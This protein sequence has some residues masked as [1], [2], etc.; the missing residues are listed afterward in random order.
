M[1]WLVLSLE[2]GP[3]NCVLDWAATVIKTHPDHKIIINTHAYMYSDNT[4]MGKDKGHK[5]L[6]DDYGIG[7][8]S[9][10]SSVNDGEQM[11]E[12]LVKKYP[13]I[14]LVTSGHVLNDGTGYLVSKGIN[15][16]FVYQMLANYQTGVE[17][18]VRGG[19]GFL[20]MLIIDPKN[21]SI[22]VKTY[23]PYIDEYKTDPDNQFTINNV[24][25]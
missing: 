22:S 1:K 15:G 9:C 14:I 8:D 12:K 5:W 13:N 18:S 4:R 6:P 24:K 11:W 16:N 2:F 17:G 19:N 10:A 3:R 7:K 21:S 23:S 20:R 25:F